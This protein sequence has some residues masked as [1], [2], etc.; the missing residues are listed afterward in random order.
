MP[1]Q[2]TDLNDR[3]K[4]L[5]KVLVE[6]YIEDGQPVASTTLARRS[7]LHLSSATIR[8]V[9]ASLEK[10]GYI[11]APH[12]SAG[13]IPTSRGYRL[14]VDTMVNINPLETPILQAV[15]EKLNNSQ[16]SVSGLIQSA[17]GVLSGITQFAGI[18][19]IPRKQIVVIR[20]IEFLQLSATKV[21]VVLVMANHDVQNR[22]IQ[23]ERDFSSAE[24]QQFSN[25]L[26]EVLVGKGVVQ[27]RDV[28][29]ND[30]KKV[31]QDMN[32]M[33]VAAIQ[34]GEKA[35][36]L[37]DTGVAESCVIAGKTNLMEYDDLGD[38]Q[39]L[40]QLL[41]AFNQKCDVLS[42]LDKCLQADGV[43]IFIGKESGYTIFDD[44]SVVTAPYRLD[45]DQMGVLG[46]IGPKRMH[47][48]KVIPVVDV[49]AKLL[50]AALKN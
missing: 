16:Q 44:C 35:L 20:Q 24:L 2:A 31:H 9:M 19:S 21:L 11:H 30:M 32:Q 42:L 47:Y 14:F 43:Q 25:Y 1:N 28:L 50:T 29:L 10:K 15:Q 22:I 27:A 38:I 40:R 12:I 18:I 36:E 41:A 3:A 17:S 46:V 49:T 39:K 7:G 26:N 48:E 34:L 33:M 8:N 13:R 5:L 45:D 23:V 37:G 6:G 4:H